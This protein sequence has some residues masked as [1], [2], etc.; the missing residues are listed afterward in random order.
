MPMTTIWLIVLIFSVVIEIVTL[1]LVSIWFS[2]GA[3]ASLIL[4]FTKV[5]T[6]IQIAIFI[7]VSLAC[8]I[9]TRPIATKYLRGNIIRTNADRI[10]GK[11]A[12]VTKSILPNNRGEVKVLGNFWTAI[13]L[14]NE[15]IEVDEEVEIVTI[16]GVKAVVKKY[17]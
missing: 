15:T 9:I 1:D 13:A 12:V 11:R 3:L 4:A 17:N 10:I 5:S 16:E 2:I 8:F 7:I 6:Q 14:D